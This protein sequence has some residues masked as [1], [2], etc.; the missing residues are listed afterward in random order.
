M[1]RVQ[2]FLQSGAP[3]H[4]VLLY[5]PFYDFIANPGKARL[6]HFGGANAPDENTA[7]EAARDLMQRRGY[8]Y[9]FVSD[10]QLRDVRVEASALVTGGGARYAIIAMPAS[11]Y[12]PLDTLTRVVELANQGATV[13]AIGGFAADVTGLADLSSRREQL[14]RAIA[15]IQFGAAD[16]GGI[17]EARVGRGRILRGDNLET[18]LARAKIARESMVD[19]GLEFARRRSEQGRFYFISNSSADD[20]RRMDSAQPVRATRAWCTIRCAARCAPR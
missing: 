8:T 16:A 20:V 6:A 10:R 4:D 11:R 13:L 18:L 15:A 19:H 1:T 5:Y 7:F 17:A 3:D 9:D 14:R 12:I 2:S